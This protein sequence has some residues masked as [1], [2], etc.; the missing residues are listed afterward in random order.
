MFKRLF[1]FITG[2]GATP[3]SPEPPPKK[4][5]HKT[6]RKQQ[7]GV[8]SVNTDD[9][10]EEA[11]AQAIQVFS[12]HAGMSLFEGKIEHVYDLAFVGQADSCPRCGSPTRQQY[13]N[14]VYATNRAPRAMAAPAG[15]FCTK[16]ATVIVDQEMLK[17][18]I[19]R[20]FRYVQVIGVTSSRNEG[21][22]GFRTWNGEKPV[23]LFD[24]NQNPIGLA[25]EN[26][27]T[28]EERRTVRSQRSKSKPKRW[29]IK[30]N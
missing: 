23:Y 16:C 30:R 11:K 25:T 21:F 19:T 10:S 12:E 24:E 17:K 1:D 13:A 9:L 4:K 7:K 18:G 8:M 28:P 29:K 20:G 15:Y 26:D 2:K 27:L 3:K 5:Q 6:G 14:W 22:E